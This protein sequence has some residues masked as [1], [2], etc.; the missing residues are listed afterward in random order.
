MAST[1]CHVSILDAGCKRRQFSRNVKATK[2]LHGIVAH[3]EDLKKAFPKAQYDG[4]MDFACQLEDGNYVLVEMQVLPK[5]N[6][7]KR[8]LAYVAAFYGNQLRKGSKWRDIKSVI[9]INILGGGA[10]EQA[11]WKGSHNQHE[12]HFKFQEQFHKQSCEM[13]I[14]GIEIF[15]Y[16]LMNVPDKFPSPERAKQDWIAF[17]KRGSRMTE[18]EVKSEIR[19]EAVLKAFERATLSK[20]PKRVKAE[21]DAENLLYSQCSEHTAELVAEGEAKG[22]AEGEAKGR[23]EGEAKGRADTLSEIVRKLKE[24]TN[25]ED[26]A[27]AKILS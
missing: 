3:F 25:L 23:A 20:L 14:E 19:T 21:Y 8:A 2:F 4:T 1:E 24:S 13:F 12:R 18:E 11:F 17:F 22:R 6:W 26:A 5:D 7:D 15:Q 27:I 10:R 16:S 9:G